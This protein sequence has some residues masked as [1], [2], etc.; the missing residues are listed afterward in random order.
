MPAVITIDQRASRGSEDRASGWAREFN[1]MFSSRYVLPFAPTVGDEIQA[2]T[3]DPQVAVE[4][5]LEGVHRGV[6]WLG[7]GLGQVEMPLGDS[8]AHS[9]GP[10]FY[11]A[12]EA[13]EHAKK[14]PY[15]FAVRAADPRLALDIQTVLELLGFVIRRRG[16]NPKR[17]QAI[18]LARS[19]ASTVRIG[20]ELGIT[21]QAASKRLRNAGL[22]EEIAG[23]RLAERLISMTMGSD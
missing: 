7:L 19:G 5:A 9:R 8:A 21:Q 15:G 4:I 6:W 14:A 10:A 12:R 13:V 18:E 2:V 16:H 23:R 20:K 1:A 22:D 11:D 17:W 3:G